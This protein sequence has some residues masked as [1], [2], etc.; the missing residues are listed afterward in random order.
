MKNINDVNRFK[1]LASS[2]NR[3]GVSDLLD[4]LNNSDFFEA[5]ASAKYHNCFEGGLC[6]HSLHVYDNLLKLNGNNEEKETKTGLW[7]ISGQ[8]RLIVRDN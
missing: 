4:Y 5:P 3:D 7:T 6:S 2:I 1:E 8:T